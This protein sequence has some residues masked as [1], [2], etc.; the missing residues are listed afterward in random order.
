MQLRLPSLRSI[1]LSSVALVATLLIALAGLFGV[2]RALS[3]HDRAEASVQAAET[4]ALM[5]GLLAVHAEALQSVRL[6]YISAG[7]DISSEEFGALMSPIP[8]YA[9]AFQR[10]WVTDSTG[11]LQHEYTI[12]R[13]GRMTPAQRLDTL[14]IVGVGDLV[15]E[16]RATRR[17]RISGTARLMTGERGIVIVEP[18]FAGERFLGV[19]GG[20]VLTEDLLGDLLRRDDG[21][22]HDLVVL[23][24]ADT[25][26]ELRWT[27]PPPFARSA[28]SRLVAPGGAEWTV[29][30]TRTVAGPWL[31]LAV[32]AIGLLTLGALLVSLLHERRQGIRLAER[33]AELERLSSELLRANRSKSEFLAN[34]S[35]ELRTPLNAIVGFVDLMREN[36]YGELTPRQAAPV[37]RI[38]SSASH[39]R[40]LVDQILDIAKM[41][42]GRVEVDREPVDLRPF[43]L[44]VVTEVESLAEERGLTTSVAVGGELPRLYTDRTH[45]R[46]I[47]FNLIG[48]AVKF[49]E[50]GGV[51]VRA[52]VVTSPSGL[53]ASAMPGTPPSVEHPW[54]AVQVL[55]TGI[56]IAAGDQERIF[57]E[58]EQ[59]NAGP[60]TDSAQRG[61][62]LGLPISRRLARLLGGEITLESELGRGSMFTLW[63]PLGTPRVAAA[64]PTPS[65]F[66]ARW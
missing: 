53:P 59:V 63:L 45:L 5:G 60:R 1:R 18:L 13:D 43:V 23:N 26:A 17:T 10:I 40:A 19:A 66:A 36:V 38:A 54:V 44:D 52:H 12:S 22:L 2:D 51:S 47:L 50:H 31:R 7:G 37:E 56:G 58:F 9:N 25:I 42:A 33:T 28:E 16:A 55:D 41:A 65:A 15:R 4:A 48:N 24:G 39:L 3:A 30:V 61:T 64:E 20:I 11:A 8:E 49:T 27:G 29:V 62:G 35:H 21:R 57:E 14:A 6:L 46:Q 34:V 32:W